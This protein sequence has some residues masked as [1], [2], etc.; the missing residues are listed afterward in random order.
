MRKE[1]KHKMP[2]EVKIQKTELRTGLMPDPR[3]TYDTTTPNL[4]VYGKRIDPFITPSTNKGNID[5]L[6]SFAKDF[7]RTG[8]LYL[9]YK[10]S[11]EGDEEAEGM[12]SRARGEELNSN[13]STAFIRGYEKL[14]GKIDGVS[15]LN[16]EAIDFF[17][18]NKDLPADEFEKK[19]SDIVMN[20]YVD[21][22]STNYLKGFLPEALATLEHTTKQHVTY[23][24]D[25]TNENLFRNINDT[26]SVDI[27]R[28]IQTTFGLTIP[29]IMFD[30]DKRLMLDNN[31]EMLNNVFP[32]QIRQL[33]SNKLNELKEM[34]ISRRD[35][36]FAIAKTIA[37]LSEKWGLPEL[38]KYT[39]IPDELGQTVINNPKLQEYLTSSIQRA[40]SAHESILRS[41]DAKRKKDIEDNK[42][43]TTNN[44]IVRIGQANGDINALQ[45]LKAEITSPE[46]Q[47][48]LDNYFPALYERIETAL[49]NGGT[50]AVHTDGMTRA[51][52]MKKGENLKLSDVLSN[53][54]KLSQSDADHFISMIESVKNRYHG[55]AVSNDWR[56]FQGNYS[57]LQSLYRT[58]ELGRFRDPI[59]GV[60]A[61]SHIWKQV[62]EYQKSHGM[63]P[64]TGDAWDKI[65]DDT[66]KRFPT[67]FMN[68]KEIYIDS[69]PSTY[70]HQQQQQQ[71]Q[72][73]KTT[74]GYKIVEKPKPVVGVRPEELE[75]MAT[76]SK[77]NKYNQ[78]NDNQNNK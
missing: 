42:S 74:S 68:P 25:M 46:M 64:P 41:L 57:S 21:G 10:K 16:A 49:A 30:Y 29:E 27:Q 75:A 15:K 22:R 5:A 36:G 50:F 69:N 71:Q 8:E 39:E 77:Q 55:E 70:K 52:L 37:N 4:E 2:K 3:E 31:R 73:Q 65:V 26:I 63:R 59:N 76:K 6:V 67:A 14:Q 34:N 58:D 19:F 62:Q 47:K 60:N 53:L 1:G 9:A 32:S 40:T 28:E 54:N 17:E 61:T 78:K 44:F 72:E 12:A 13:K 18:K 38:I 33:V 45:G 48:K 56:A 11:Q 51:M 43:L 7:N 35:A 66:I 23:I 24:R 20:K